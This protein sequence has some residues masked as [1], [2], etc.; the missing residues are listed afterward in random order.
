[1]K[2]LNPPC[3][4]GHNNSNVEYS[5]DTVSVQILPHYALPIGITYDGKYVSLL[6]G[7][8]NFPLFNC[9]YEGLCTEYEETVLVPVVIEIRMANPVIVSTSNNIIVIKLNVKSFV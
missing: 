7:D 8:R 3:P 1:M 4:L 5:T 2:F 6:G 9:E